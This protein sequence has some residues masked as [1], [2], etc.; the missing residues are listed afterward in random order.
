MYSA[1]LRKTERFYSQV[2]WYLKLHISKPLSNSKVQYNLFVYNKKK[3]KNLLLGT[4]GNSPI[5]RQQNVLIIPYR[6]G[7]NN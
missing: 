2:Y 3:T 7:H 5:Y 6:K 4:R 1:S